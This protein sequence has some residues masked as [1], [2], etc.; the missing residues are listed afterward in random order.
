MWKRE[1]RS[2]PIEK[3]I[4]FAPDSQSETLASLFQQC[5]LFISTRCSHVYSA[6]PCLLLDSPIWDSRLRVPA[7][8]L[9][10]AS[11][12]NFCSIF[13][14]PDLIMLFFVCSLNWAIPVV[15]TGFCE[16]PVWW[17][18]A[19]YLYF[20]LATSWYLL[21]YFCFLYTL[22]LTENFIE[23]LYEII[24]FKDYFLDLTKHN[25]CSQQVPKMMLLFWKSDY[26][27]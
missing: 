7:V 20:S 21:F 6:T 16:C 12:I 22:N 9:I 10:K 27:R 11:M 23:S 4:C 13:I 18:S 24:S 25:W 3:V 26:Y 14:S 8:N 1:G 5:S 15:S 19:A 2:S 17:C